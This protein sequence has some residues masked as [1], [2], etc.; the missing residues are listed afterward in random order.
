MPTLP[1][2]QPLNQLKRQPHP[3][4]QTLSNLNFSLN[5]ISTAQSKPIHLLQPSS[6]LKV[7][8]NRQPT[9]LHHKIHTQKSH[10]SKTKD[11]S[12]TKAVPLSPSQHL[13]RQH[14]R[15]TLI[16]FPFAIKNNFKEIWS[17][18]IMFNPYPDLILV[19]SISTAKQQHYKNPNGKGFEG[20]FLNFTKLIV[21]HKITSVQYV[22][23]K[24]VSTIVIFLLILRIM[25]SGIQ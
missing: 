7:K 13:S 12:Y 23:I 2:I 18:K 1:P 5:S 3:L 24:I 10:V 20:E 16:S 19:S 17:T 6:Q 14:D 11:H 8:S 9:P 21:D 4:I 25:K 22:S 15:P